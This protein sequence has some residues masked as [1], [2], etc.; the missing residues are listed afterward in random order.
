MGY[1][2]RHKLEILEG[3]D[4]VTDHKDNI[5]K[6]SGYSDCFDDDIKWYDHVDNMTTYSKQHPT[7]VFKLSGEG[8]ESGDIWTEYYCNG[9]MQ[10]EKAEI[11][12]GVFDKSKLK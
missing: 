1:Y 8:E 7:V 10:R 6:L 2:T 3:D 4:F 11:V 9:K 5:S 12:V